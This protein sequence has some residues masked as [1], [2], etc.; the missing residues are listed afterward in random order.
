MSTLSRF[1]SFSVLASS[2]KKDSALKISTS[3]EVLF[4]VKKLEMP[5][6]Y[7]SAF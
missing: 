3:F 2:T 6:Y 5:S 4:K 7:I 1:Y